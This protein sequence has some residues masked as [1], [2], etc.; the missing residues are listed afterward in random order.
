MT[1]RVE[2]TQGPGRTLS[3]TRM[4]AALRYG[5]SEWVVPADMDVQAGRDP[6]LTGGPLGAFGH[7]STSGLT[8]TIDTGESFVA[9]GYVARDTQ[10]PVTVPAS[11]TSYIAVGYDYTQRPDAN[12][13]DALILDV[14]SNFPASSESLRLW[15]V[16]ANTSDVTGIANRR[17][18]GE[19]INLRNKEY[20]SN[21]NGVVD[22]AESARTLSG[23]YSIDWL[24]R[25]VHT[26]TIKNTTVPHGE[27]A[28][29]VEPR[30]AGETIKVL[31]AGAHDH[32]GDQHYGLYARIYRVASDGTLTLDYS[33][34]N[35]NLAEGTLSDP[36][37]QHTAGTG[38]QTYWLVI[39]N[40]WQEPEAEVSGTFQYVVE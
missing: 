35:E 39:E 38:G 15:E 10:T 34:G 32:L 5:G 14:E 27:R 1:D 22:E 20:D 21:L 2:P 23:G 26:S 12:G 3:S 7:V 8:V 6:D 13:D 17:P 29:T 36:L 18:L 30:E 40:Q 33:R 28:I 24:A 25:R 16:T 37:Y 19:Q 4:Q 9:G 31:R 11:T